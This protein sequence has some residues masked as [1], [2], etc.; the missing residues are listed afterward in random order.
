M[1]KN[2]KRTRAYAQKHDGECHNIIR[3]YDRSGCHDGKAT[4]RAFIFRHIDFYRCVPLDKKA[5]VGAE[6][7]AKP[8]GPGIKLIDQTKFWNGVAPLPA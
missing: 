2:Q 1:N 8:N 5:K 7:T 6:P 3:D 4:E